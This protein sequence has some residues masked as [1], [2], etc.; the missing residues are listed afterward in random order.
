MTKHPTIKRPLFEMLGEV[1]VHLKHRDG[2]L[3]EHLLQLVVSIDLALVLRVLKVVAL[4]VV[5]NL[6]HHLGRGSGSEPTTAA[7]SLDGCKGF[8]SAGLTFLPDAPLPA[9][10]SLAG[11]PSAEPAFFAGVL[12]AAVGLAFLAEVPLAVSAFLGGGGCL[13][14]LGIVGVLSLVRAL[15][16]VDTSRTMNG[17]PGSLRSSALSSDLTRALDRCR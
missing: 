13:A 16:V 5:P 15:A 12:L 11:V 10:A 6:A 9:P 3:A 4:D 8:I 14:L 2:L 17:A 7:S 1:F